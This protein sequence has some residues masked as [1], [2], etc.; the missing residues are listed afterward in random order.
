[1]NYFFQKALRGA[2]INAEFLCRKQALKGT[3]MKMKETPGYEK[4]CSE[5]DSMK[6]KIKETLEL[7]Q[8]CN[9]NGS[10]KMKMKIVETT[11]LNKRLS[12]DGSMKMKIVETS[13]LKKKFNSTVEGEQE[14][15]TFV[16]RE[17]DFSLILHIIE[18]PN[19]KIKVYG[20]SCIE[21]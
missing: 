7:N 3:S 19:R 15:I 17:C 8:R 5:D 10:M 20:T 18:T 6:K 13:E 11:E 14:N 4:I 12:E 2:N 16:A 21:I 1:M 9:E